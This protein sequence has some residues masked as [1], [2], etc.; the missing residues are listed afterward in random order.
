MV[1]S[2]KDITCASLE[3]ALR[4]VSMNVVKILK[5]MKEKELITIIGSVRWQDTYSGER[6]RSY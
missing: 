2:Q 1:D 5:E 3:K 6:K 4:I